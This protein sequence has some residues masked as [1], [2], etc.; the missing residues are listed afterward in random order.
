MLDAADCNA[1]D[2]PRFRSKVYFATPRALAAKD[3]AVGALVDDAVALVARAGF[4]SYVAEGLGIL[5]LCRR[6][7]STGG[8]AFSY[9]LGALPHTVFTDWSDDP[10][11]VGECLLHESVHAWLNAVLSAAGEQLPSAPLAYSPWKESKR[12][13]F[14]LIHAG[15][16]F[17]ILTSYFRATMATERVS[18]GTQRYCQVRADI[19]R[20]RLTAAHG[21]VEE[22]LS[23]VRSQDIAD[24]IRTEMARAMEP[25]RGLCAYG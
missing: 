8:A 21:G 5:I 25:D 2:D 20:R 10:H 16:A 14:G 18:G 15:F 22:A 4:L 9:N 6:V 19:E 17:S 24:L 23:F 12:P 11:V 3:S 7:P 1:T 13:A